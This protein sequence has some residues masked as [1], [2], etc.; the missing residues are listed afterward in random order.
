M[1]ETYKASTLYRL[2]RKYVLW[3]FRNYY[4]EYIV[5]GEDNIPIDE[6]IIFAANHLNALMDAM[7]VISLPPHNKAKFFLARADLFKLARPIVKFLRFSKLIP[8]YRIRDGYENLDKNKASFEEADNVLIN[9]ATLAIMPEGNQGDEKKI[10]PLGKGIFRI[11]FSA[12]QKLPI[13]KSVKII[14]VGI[15]M[16]HLVKFGEHIIIQVG[17]PI[18]VLDYMQMYEENQV[19]AINQLRTKLKDE[20]GSLV[21]NLSTNKY[22]TCFET[23]IDVVEHRMLQELELSD[24]TINR[25]YA[26]QKIA[27]LLVELEK[28][29]PEEIEKL[30]SLSKPYRAGLEKV[31]LRSHTLEMPS[32]AIPTPLMVY[33]RSF[34]YVLIG[35]PGYILNKL[36]FTISTLFVKILKIEYKGFYSSVYFAISIVS[37]PLMYLL[38]SLLIVTCFALPWWAFILLLPA[39]YFAGKISFLLYKKINTDFAK[40]R[41]RQLIKSKKEDYLQLT[42]LKS[43]ITEL[44][45]KQFVR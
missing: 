22:Y 38:Q 30:D 34:I 40:L 36:P 33:L 4:D 28:D 11:A 32:E 14:P 29:H 23:T 8:A 44:V 10:R 2:I 42:Y 6:P 45:A 13:G 39:H 12:Q 7:A 1:S 17:K 37:F 31:N 16:G 25:F 15:D 24:N 19:E 21:Q 9:N 20:M 5:V 26:G 18:D 41:L 3:V 27:K 35:I 43:Q